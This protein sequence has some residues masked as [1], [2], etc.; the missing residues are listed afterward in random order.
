MDGDSSEGDCNFTT[1]MT[2]RNRLLV[3]HLAHKKSERCAFLRLRR[4][5][6]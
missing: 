1:A 3:A 5:R 2:V 6:P 4:L